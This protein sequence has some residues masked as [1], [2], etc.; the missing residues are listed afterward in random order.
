[1]DS[2]D[3]EACRAA[4]PVRQYLA[5]AADIVRKEEVIPDRQA[6]PQWREPERTDLRLPA[7]TNVNL[8]AMPVPS[9][10]ERSTAMEKIKLTFIHPTE[11]DR[12]LTAAVP[13]D[14]TAKQ[15]ISEMIKA[16]FISAPTGEGVQYRLRNA[17]TNQQLLD[18]TTLTAAG[19]TSGATL[20][21]DHTTTGA[22]QG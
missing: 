3:F 16:N 21:V 7:P 5:A 20:M 17:E 10:P 19:V 2:T 4:V 6:S 18:N 1:V 9:S 14:A 15:V 11:S 12:R 13:P 22:K 8:P